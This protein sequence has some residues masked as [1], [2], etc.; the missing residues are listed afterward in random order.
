M[1]FDIP[2]EDTVALSDVGRVRQLNEDALLCLPAMGVFC[3]ADGMGG[4]QEG[5]QASYAVVEM[6]KQAFLGPPP[7][8]LVE[9]RRRAVEAIRRANAWIRERVSTQGLQSMGSTV[10]VLLLDEACPRHALVLHAGDSRCYRYSGRHLVAVTRDH[11]MAAEAGVRNEDLNAMFRGVLTRGVGMADSIEL[12]ETAVEL[13]EGDLLLLCSDGLHS[14]APVREI[15]AALKGCAGGSL[16]ALAKALVAAAN[17]AGGKDNVTVLL[18]RVSRALLAILPADGDPTP[19]PTGRTTD[20]TQPVADGA[21]METGAIEQPDSANCTTVAMD[22]PPT[23]SE[24]K[25]EKGH[26][27]R[28]WIGAS[29][30]VAAAVTAFTAFR[31]WTTRPSPTQKTITQS[32]VTVQPS[33]LTAAATSTSTATTCPVPTTTTT[34]STTT[35]TTV[36]RPPVEVAADRVATSTPPVPP[37]VVRP[38]LTPL[39]VGATTTSTSTSTTGSPPQLTPPTTTTTTTTSTSTTCPVPTTTTTTSTT[40]TTTVPPSD[41]AAAVE[42]S[43]DICTRLVRIASPDLLWPLWVFNRA[44][45]DPAGFV[46]AT[47]A[48]ARVIGRATRPGEALGEADLR[49]F[50]TSMMAQV[51]ELPRSCAERQA[52]DSSGGI[53]ERGRR[54]YAAWNRLADRPDQ[55]L[56]EHAVDVRQLLDLVKSACESVKPPTSGGIP[57]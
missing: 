32:R 6:L 2:G 30:A 38:P 46:A 13:A 17:A 40:T 53:L 1:P 54:L 37:T 15:E 19:T 47:S 14:V 33:P 21:A 49:R 39:P 51:E 3:V 50:L 25:R 42:P 29:V 5:Q 24:A 26:Q 28:W 35:T 9:K 11:S 31:L 8:N 10:V 44:A 57:P 56:N 18:V 22:V 20:R 12:E 52:W 41:P 43:G 36:P 16:S 27:V 23:P 55:F 45:Q 4:A 7:V 34:T 48:V